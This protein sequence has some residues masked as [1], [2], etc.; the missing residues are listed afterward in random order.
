MV[1]KALGSMLLYKSQAAWLVFKRPCSVRYVVK[2]NSLF[3]EKTNS[4]SLLFVCL[5]VC[6]F[7]PPFGNEIHI[8][9]RDMEVFFHWQR[10]PSSVLRFDMRESP[11]WG[12]AD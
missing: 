9:D 4:A 5:F 10:P 12:A 7:L 3:G 1:V 11:Q 2:L 6:F 8:H